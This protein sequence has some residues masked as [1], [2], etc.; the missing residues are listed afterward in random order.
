[1]GTRHATSV[2][3]VSLSSKGWLLDQRGGNSAFC[4][5]PGFSGLLTLEPI[6]AI[7]PDDG[8]VSFSWEIWP[9][10]P[11]LIDDA[12]HPAAS[13]ISDSSGDMQPQSYL[14]EA[15]LLEIVSPEEGANYDVSDENY[16]T[17]PPIPFRAKVAPEEI[18]QRLGNISW[19]LNLEYDTTI[20]RGPWTSQKTFQTQH[21]EIHDET[22]SS[23]GGR[24]DVNVEASLDGVTL[25]ANQVFTVTG[26]PIP[27][28]VITAR[29]INLYNGT[30]PNLLTGIAAVESGVDC[31]CQFYE[32]TKYGVTDLWPR[33]SYD[34]G[35]HIGLMQVPVTMEDA[36][37][38]LTNTQ[39]AVDNHFNP[40]L[41]RSHSKV[42]EIRAQYPELPE[43][44]D[45]QHENNAL[46]IYRMGWSYP[47]HFYYVPNADHS[48][49]IVNSANPTGVG[50]ADDVRENLR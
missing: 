30:T 24:G 47:Q 4:L 38:W 8:T 9:D 15:P 50:Y 26:I 44:T 19:T 32:M 25:T 36:W 13:P 31:Y 45:V 35:S 3:L 43:L 7:E 29:L 16:T 1:M 40:A 5:R 10:D 21:D 6:E 46:S 33:E 37:N 22:Y 11:V 34:G 28:E 14:V 49:W 18:S 41:G 2:C 20:S 23:E 48:A 42:T 39:T 27:E 12:V 17:T